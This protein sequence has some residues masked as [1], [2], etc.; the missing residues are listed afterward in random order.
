MYPASFIHGFDCLSPQA[1]QLVS[2]L[3]R[4]IAASI[5]A[6]RPFHPKHPPKPSYRH[7]FLKEFWSNQFDLDICFQLGGGVGVSIFPFEAGH[8][9]RV[10]VREG[11]AAIRT[12]LL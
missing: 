5:M 2:I 12:I 1:L 10:L 9:Q 8:G 3:G 4:S 7:L 11:L 6:P